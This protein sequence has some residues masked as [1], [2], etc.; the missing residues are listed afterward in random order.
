MSRIGPGFL[1]IIPTP[2]YLNLTVL[3]SQARGTAL[4]QCPAQGDALQHR[5]A[6]PD[7]VIVHLILKTNP[8]EAKSW[9][10][11]EISPAQRPDSE[12]VDPGT[13]WTR[14]GPETRPEARFSSL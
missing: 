5:A 9:R 14:A 10:P 12:R 6:L 7:F 13:R 2:Q 3:E 1:R 4:Q 11:G 8:L